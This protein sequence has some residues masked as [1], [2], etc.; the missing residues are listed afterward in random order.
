MDRWPAVAALPWLSHGLLRWASLLCRLP[1]LPRH[2]PLRG[3]A[4]DCFFLAFCAA[5][6][7]FHGMRPLRIC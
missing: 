4:A 2:A 7:A 5:L 3:S 6:C 1:R